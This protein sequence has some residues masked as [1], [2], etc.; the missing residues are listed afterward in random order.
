[1][2]QDKFYYDASYRI[3]VTL[4]LRRTLQGSVR[5]SSNET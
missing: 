3:S 4:A 5:C 2:A 1:V